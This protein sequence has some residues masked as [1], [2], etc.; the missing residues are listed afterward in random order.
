MAA[1]KFSVAV[2]GFQQTERVFLNSAFGLSARRT[3]AFIPF[4]ATQGGAPDVY[5]VDTKATN[6]VEVLQRNNANRQ[7]PAILIGEDNLGLGWPLL[8][9]PLQLTALF[10]AFDMAIQT[11]APNLAKAAPAALAP[12]RKIQAPENEARG[13]LFP[14]SVLVASPAPAAAPKPREVA[15]AEWVLVCDDS[16]TVREFMRQRLQP[17]R[18]NVDYAE[19]GEQAIGLTGTKHYACVFLDVMMPGIDGYQVCKLIK[20]I[21]RVNQT[22]VIMLTGK[23][24]PFDKIRGTM[25]GCD[26]YLTKPVNEDKL[27]EVINRYLPA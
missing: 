22:A 25:A 2:L 1:G 15:H 7:R 14:K 16:S 4:D 12:A 26:A 5:L 18:L 8:G 6:A 21:K 20:S 10:K 19:S 3:P 17:Y 24:S 23:T 27:L 13:S 11:A 9:R